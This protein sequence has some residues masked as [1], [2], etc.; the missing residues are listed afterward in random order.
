[1]MASMASLS[2]PY[3]SSFLGQK[4]VRS[5]PTSGKVFL[6]G[7]HPT[8]AMYGWA[9]SRSKRKPPP[10]AADG[11]LNV[12]KDLGFRRDL[13]EHYTVPDP[14]TTVPL[15]MGSYG[16]VMKVSCK[17][18]GTEYAMKSIP[19]TPPNKRESKSPNAYLQKLENEVKVMQHV[20]PSLNV[21]YLYNVF[22]DDTHIHL[23]LEYCRGGELWR[24]IRNGK[25]S[26]AYAAKIIRSILRVVAQCHAKN[27]IYRDI[28]PDNFLF[29]N[30]RQDSPLKATDFGLATYYTPGEVLTRRCGTPSYL[31]PEVVMR[32]Y[33]PEADNW[34]TGVTVYQ[35]LSGKLPFS[36]QRG[37]IK[38]VLRAVLED[39]VVLDDEFWTTKISD[40]ARDLTTRLLDRNPA[41]RLTAQ[42]ALE[43][44]WVLA[45][46][47]APDT[48]LCGSVV[49]RLQRFGTFPML[50]RTVLRYIAPIML[51]EDS[52][53]G[54][55]VQVN[56]LYSIFREFD[57]AGDGRLTLQDLMLGLDKAGYSVDDSEIEQLMTHMDVN[58]DG[59]VYYDEF[60]ATMI[61]W[62]Q[63]EQY[64]SEHFHHLVDRAFNTLDGQ[65]QGV[66]DRRSIGRL[67]CQQ[68]DT[69]E[70]CAFIV[71]KCMGEADTDGDGYISREDFFT[72]LH[73]DDHDMLDQYD[74]RIEHLHMSMDNIEGD[75]RLVVPKEDNTLYGADGEPMTKS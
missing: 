59:V 70:E 39:P 73:T 35:L 51:Q 29:L 42:E 8:K 3:S 15:G 2:T 1:M 28:K 64:D 60:L 22:E 17:E 23:V 65:D 53:L 38:E 69:A 45:G 75:G 31:A 61:D 41:T 24:R 19:K 48:P 50:K 67:L 6:R 9:N 52:T 66:I 47:E 40:G 62:L 43:H 21:V 14:Q 36:S 5:T 7:A 74:D 11:V 68:D 4:E 12:G 33:G 56:E 25:Y 49:Q 63:V 26:E 72:L 30:T 13:H 58:R 27:V 10:V 71:D 46:G 16:V 44:P 18:T 34:S 55:L 37:S 54:S 32:K 57:R 20:G